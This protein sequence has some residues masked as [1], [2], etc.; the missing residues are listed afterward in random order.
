MSKQV[1]VHLK[2]HHVNYL[3]NEQLRTQQ[4]SLTKTLHQLID[5]RIESDPNW[6]QLPCSER[7]EADLS[8]HKLIDDKVQAD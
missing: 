2:Q 3:A 4:A 7:L 8:L 1:N 6:Q 5:Q